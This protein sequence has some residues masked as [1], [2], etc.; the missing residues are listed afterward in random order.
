[1]EAR[2]GLGTRN[3]FQGWTLPTFHPWLRLRSFCSA[4]HLLLLFTGLLFTTNIKPTQPKMGPKS[5]IKLTIKK[6]TYVT[7]N[8]KSVILL[9]KQSAELEAGRVAVALAKD[10]RLRNSPL[11]GCWSPSHFRNFHRTMAASRSPF[12]YGF[13]DSKI[14]ESKFA[15]SWFERERHEWY[16]NVNFLLKLNF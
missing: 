15:N 12:I 1:M 16:V 4:I 11:K 3:F 14:F 13:V 7:T 2:A 6:T 10:Q 9:N 5:C 8:F